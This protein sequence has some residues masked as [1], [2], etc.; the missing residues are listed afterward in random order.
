MDAIYFLDKLEK[1]AS[2][3]PDYHIIS[4]DRDQVII[5]HHSS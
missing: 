2:G 3:S 5:D 1:D 4:Q